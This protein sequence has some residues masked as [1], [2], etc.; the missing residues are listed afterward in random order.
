MLIATYYHVVV[1]HD[2]QIQSSMATEK[3]CPCRMK[4]SPGYILTCCIILGICIQYSSHEKSVVKNNHT[5]YSVKT[6]R[7]LFPYCILSCWA[8]RPLPK[9]RGCDARYGNWRTWKATTNTGSVL[10]HVLA[11]SRIGVGSF[12]SEA[13]SETGPCDTICLNC[14]SRMDIVAVSLCDG[15]NHRTH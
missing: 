14:N 13:L 11:R 12:G 3:N 7:R 8:I 6:V 15:R 10:T 5:R 9:H 2:V 1:G 4:K